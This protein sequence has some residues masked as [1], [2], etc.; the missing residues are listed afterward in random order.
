[1]M[2]FLATV[3]LEVTLKLLLTVQEEL[4]VA[5]AV[6]HAHDVAHSHTH[7]QA[8]AVAHSHFQPFLFQFKRNRVGHIRKLTDL[9]FRVQPM[10]AIVTKECRDQLVTK[11]ET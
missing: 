10:D 5:H 1:M 7:A 6:A 11:L 8:H 4:G 9:D 3:M 2:V